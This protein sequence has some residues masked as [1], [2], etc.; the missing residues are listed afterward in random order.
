MRPGNTIED[1]LSI[2]AKHIEVKQKR[3]QALSQQEFQ[4]LYYVW[5]DQR[6]EER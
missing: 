4:L 6:N 3:G 1:N 5:I 2:V